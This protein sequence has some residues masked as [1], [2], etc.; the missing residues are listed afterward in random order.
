MN[1]AS[2]SGFD[3]EGTAERLVSDEPQLVCPEQG[4]FCSGGCAGFKMVGDNH[5]DQ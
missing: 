2:P 1:V 4:G 3:T 5:L